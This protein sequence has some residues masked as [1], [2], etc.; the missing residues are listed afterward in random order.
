MDTT[1]CLHRRISAL[2]FLAVLLL[3]GCAAE[4]QA[5]RDVDQVDVG[6]ELGLARARI[7]QLTSTVDSAG[8]VHLAGLTESGDVHYV[9]ID[10]NGTAHAEIIGKLPPGTGDTAALDIIEYPPGTIRL[11]VGDTEHS[12]PLAGGEWS[13]FGGN[14]CR[15]YLVVGVSL[16][17]AFV[18]SGEEVGS[19][20][21]KDW[22]GYMLVILPFI[23]PKTV[24]PGKLVLA[25][26]GETSW[27][28]RAVLDSANNWSAHERDFTVCADEQGMVH[29]VFRVWRGGTIHADQPG[30]FIIPPTSRTIGQEIEVRYAQVRLAEGRA[31]GGTRA[32]WQE[33]QSE[34]IELGV[35]ALA[36]S[37]SPKD[38]MLGL[39]A[40][41]AVLP[42]SGVALALVAARQSSLATVVVNT[43]K[44]DI[45]ALGTYSW[46]GPQYQY[47]YSP[48]LR[49]RGDDAPHVLVSACPVGFH[50]S[51]ETCD[52]RMVYVTRRA[53]GRLAIAPLE[54]AA[55]SMFAA[56]A[57]AVGSQ[58]Q[59]FAAWATTDDRLVG[60]W[61]RPSSPL[62]LPVPAP[63][64]R[65]GLTLDLD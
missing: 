41:V 39:R 30:F 59:V 45:L 54:G 4:L 17:C 22:S 55:A 5:E 49:V 24:Q 13:R 56:R 23:W 35:R 42:K 18:A 14:R 52:G 61:I 65:L 47:D 12:R 16:Y 25:E 2:A 63:G 60:R 15:Q 37:G 9:V 43:N 40:K 46:G 28:V 36:L 27:T 21:R 44:V 34:R 3:S 29:A 33:A 48:V 58:G 38:W 26:R 64:R 32:E 8:S 53:S 10:V 51:P 20:P 11:S 6:P 57:L 31:S 19:A 1:P 7:K 62:S 50:K